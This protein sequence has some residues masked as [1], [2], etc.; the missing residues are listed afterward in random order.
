MTAPSVEPRRN[1]QSLG[2]RF[3]YALIGVVTV[4]LLGFAVVAGFVS[5]ARVS[6][7]L[8]RRAD[9]ALQ[10]AAISLP[11]TLR[12]GDIL[13][14]DD[15][16]KAIMRDDAIAFMMV[17]EQNIVIFREARKEF[18]NRDLEYFK[19]SPQFI[20]KQ[21]QLYYSDIKTKD[22][23]V[24]STTLVVSRRNIKDEVVKNVLG[25]F[26][27]TVSIIVAIALTS[28]FITRRY[29]SGPLS[30]LQ[31]SAALIASGDLNAPVDKSGRD[32]IGSLAQDLDA[33]RESIKE[34]TENLE[35]K[36][37]ARTRD[38][39]ESLEQ[40]TATSD[41]LRAISR[42][43]RDLQP[44]FDIIAESAARLCGAAFCVVN[45][46]DSGLLHIVGQFGL[47]GPALEAYQGA[48]PMAPKRDSAAGR[49]ILSGRVAHIPDIEADPDYRYADL[50]HVVTYRSIVAVPIIHDG[51]AIGTITASRAVAEP[52][53][54]KQLELLAVFAEQ[55]VIAIETA[56]LF[57]E[58]QA[59]TQQLTQSVDELKAL[60][61][62]SQALSTT[63]DLE[64]VLAT[65]VARAVELS[66]ADA[67]TIYEFN[68]SEEVFVPRANFGMSEELVEALR[69][70][71][72]RMNE[73]TVGKAGARRAAFQIPD[74]EEDPTYRLRNLHKRAG[75]RAL[76][77][78]PLFHEERI[79][80]GLVVRKKIPG[81]YPQEIVALLQT[82]AAQSALA[83]QNARLFQ[84]VQEK[85]QQLEIA[86]QHKS[87]FVANMSHELRTPLNAIIGYSEMMEE[88]AQELGQEGF[89]PDLRNINAAG[90]HLLE[91]I[92]EILD[93]SKI[94]AGKMDLFLETFDVP[95]LIH[96]VEA[97]VQPLV[98]K[99]ANSLQVNCAPAVG[100]MHADLTKVRQ[101]LF[102]LLSNASKFTEHGTI[103]LEVVVEA[104]NDHPW[105]RFRVSDSGIG[106]TPEQ[107]EKLFKTFSQADA[108][109]TREFGG[110]GLGL[111]ISRLFCQMMGGDVTVESTYGEGSSFTVRLPIE[112]VEAKPLLPPSADQLPQRSVPV[113]EDAPTVLVI[114]D[115]PAVRDLME[116]F[117][118]KEGLRMVAA[119][120]GKE[121][122]R[123]A[124]TLLPDA[125]TLD[126][127]M[128]IM[129]GWD[130]LAALKADNAL[131][132]IPVIMITI[133][134]EKH[135]GYSLG[136]TDYLTKP[137]DWKRLTVVMQKYH[138]P[139][140]TARVLIVEDDV[141]T[142]KMMR[143]RLEKQGSAV[144]EAENG[145]VALDRM[146]ESTPDLI[147]LDLMMPEMD[148]FE[149]LD[150]VHAHAD[151]RAI[152]TIVV[153]AKDITDADR[154]RL[155]GYVEGILR[156]GAYK[157]NDLLR[158]IQKLVKARIESQ[159]EE[160]METT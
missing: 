113:P 143:A 120:D 43:P 28:I 136:A 18:E 83:M 103:T 137:V 99:K 45:K 109:T 55:A 80:G 123:L 41:I 141:R 138:R 144:I 112:V 22:Q 53:P 44:V 98:E 127:L 135:V 3:S 119:S 131:A 74:I 157:A 139:G 115:D 84:E 159:R 2:R 14:V 49:A 88:E 37:D 114:D 156:K 36:V 106:M 130:V 67:G 118:N 87:Q 160:K 71:R 23:Y 108:S 150:H 64:T 82:F 58:L 47:E 66:K 59:R 25:I 69:E 40:Q 34:A 146:A 149:F 105:I 121:G 124:K 134:D 24:G 68:E 148:G 104:V 77:A 154:A 46:F 122:L 17:R 90:K 107:M 95:T 56:R 153:T 102:N 39:A 126:V 7:E 96:E 92:N 9:H 76:L 10:L 72:I 38:L 91:L 52:F 8:E 20:V 110:T 78:V 73:G 75:F 61:E 117:L 11:I 89:L 133:T 85:S 111:A 132:D 86:S 147:L 65:I 93:L 128:P 32:E 63:L 33:M 140:A 5:S 60:G 12:K 100:S 26:A 125:I 94:E 51:S 4:V 79:I 81:E 54:E 6:T 19:N 57:Q 101:V 129:D 13:V 116:R 16:A 155:S 21:K 97:T 145:R 62:I 48:F 42:S 35:K 158:E 151:W 152:P 15:I 1:I 29:I 70:S 50:A 142:R 31:Q 27:L 30:K